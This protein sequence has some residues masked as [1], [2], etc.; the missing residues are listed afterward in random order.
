MGSIEN[1]SRTINEMKICTVTKDAYLYKLGLYT[2]IRTICTR[3]VATG[4]YR[5]C[6]LML[7]FPPHLLSLLSNLDFR[8]VD[9]FFYLFAAMYNVHA[10]QASKS[11][12]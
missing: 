8:S 12:T 10:I 5:V 1:E 3:K 2:Q 6:T 7:G 11:A 4:E 9:S